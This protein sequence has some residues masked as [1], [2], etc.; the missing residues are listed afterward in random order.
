VNRKLKNFSPHIKGTPGHYRLDLLPSSVPD[1]PLETRWSRLALDAWGSLAKV[2]GEM[3]HRL[4]HQCEYC[5]K[6]FFSRQMKKY[7]RECQPKYFSEK[8][9]KEGRFAERMKWYRSRKSSQGIK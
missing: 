2:M 4:F 1:K 8:Y 5:K 6:I 9:K 3:D 7:H